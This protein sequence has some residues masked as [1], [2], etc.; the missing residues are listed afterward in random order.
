MGIIGREQEKK[1]LDNLYRSSKAE[2]LALYGRRRVGKTFL[3]REFY[4]CKKGVFFEVVGEK[5]AT[6]S[7]QINNFMSKVEEKFTDGLQLKRP[8]TWKEVFKTFTNF[9]VKI[10]KK[11]KIVIFMDE[12][13][14]LASKKSGFIQALDYYFNSEWSKL[15]NLVL[16]VCGSAASWMLEKL[17]NARGGLHNRL[18]RTIHLRPFTLV[19]TAKFL[20]SSN[21]SYPPK[22]IIDL[23]MSIGGIPYYLNYLERGKSVAQNINDLCFKKDGP[24]QEEFNKLFSSLFE[25]SEISEKIVREISKSRYGISRNEL[26]KKMSMYSGGRFNL[27]LSEL[28]AAGFID[29]RIPFGK[30]KKD[31]WIKLIDEYSYFYLSWIENIKNRGH[32]PV[33]YWQK[34]QV[35]QKWQSWA[36]YAF[37]IVCMKH[38]DEILRLLNIEME[39]IQVGGFR[40]LPTKK[41]DQGIQIDLV[42]ERS[43]N[44]INLCEIKYANKQYSIDKDYA[45]KVINR[46]D[47]FKEKTKTNKNIMVNFISVY[48][49]KRN[50]WYEE[51]VD[52]EAKIVD[53]L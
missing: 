10:D 53:L 27:R 24:L 5:D 43:D 28:E 11:K 48:G 38:I 32:I 18:T 15:N 20:K 46:T 17:I 19:E 7:E 1:I 37:E 4:S 36:G 9:F 47:I 25:H 51:L 2:F 26:L 49:L 44:T 52:G 50:A 30:T 13:P 3:I 41:S 42:I 40:Y 22:D 33:G 45:R 34:Q 31:Y 29:I 8:T 16:I 6:R 23:Y 39:T 12:L 35:S 14:W 21:I